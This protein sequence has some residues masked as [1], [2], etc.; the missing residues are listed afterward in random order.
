MALTSPGAEAAH[1][2]RSLKK[3]QRQK[4]E[5]RRLIRMTQREKVAPRKVSKRK[6]L[7]LELNK[8]NLIRKD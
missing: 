5:T 6:S 4:R 7:E 3:Q 1:L 8:K 2:R